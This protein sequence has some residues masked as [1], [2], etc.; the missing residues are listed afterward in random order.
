MLNELHYSP[1]SLNSD[2]FKGLIGFLICVVPILLVNMMPWI[3]IILFCS[4]VLFVVFGGRAWARRYTRIIIDDR[5][6]TMQGFMSAYITWQDLNHL[7]LSYYSTRRNRKNGWMQ[8]Q[9]KSISQ[10]FTVDSNLY[11]F[12]ELCKKAYIAATNNDLELTI[13]TRRNL[14]ELG[15]LRINNPTLK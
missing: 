10:G 5:G 12:E 7:K 14:A 3:M 2:M 13:N 6:V 9:L 8:L 11:G 15:I 1:S 4:A